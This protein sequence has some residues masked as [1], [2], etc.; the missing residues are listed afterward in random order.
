MGRG[1]VQGGEPPVGLAVH[2][3]SVLQET[4]CHGDAAPAAG[5]VQRRPAVNGS[6]VQQG[7]GGQQRARHAHVPPVGR[8]VQGRITVFITATHQ[9]GVGTQQLE[10]GG[11]LERED[12]RKSGVPLSRT[13][14]GP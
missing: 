6:G 4:R 1:Q 3:G 13:T 7:A 11:Q 10:D 2:I 14:T 12:G 5:A 8:T 9:R